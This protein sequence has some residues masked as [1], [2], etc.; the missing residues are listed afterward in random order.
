MK[1]I[2][3]GTGQVGT[4]IAKQLAS[5]NNEVTVIDYNAD[6]IRKITDTLDVNAVIGY[7][8]HPPTLEQAGGSYS[9]MIIAVTASDEVNMVICQVAYSLFSIP[10]KIARVRNQLYLDD[11]WKD[12]YRQNHLPI[13]VIISPELEVAKAINH[14]L[15]V[16][17]AV[18]TIPYD[19]NVKLI[20]VR[21]TKYSPVVNLFTFKIKQL[22]KQINIAIIGIFR[23]Q[24]FIFPDDKEPI[25]EGDE[26]FFF[27][28]ESNVTEAMALF[29]HEEEEARKIIIVG[30]GNIGLYL[31]QL[32]EEEA[33]NVNVKIIE[34]DSHRADQVAQLLNH[35]SI[36][37]GN[38][39]DEEI[40]EESGVSYAETV[41]AVSNDDEVNILSALLAKR[42]GTQR[43][44]ALINN[45]TYASLIASLGIDVV[46]NPREITVS[47]ILGQIRRGRIKSAHTICNGIIEI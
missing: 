13:D 25:I 14:R 3:C 43:S 16:P 30:G 10:I 27:A 5:E 37:N 35:S 36:I 23:D 6:K 33:H 39:L 26:I 15:H 4:S 7:A 44:I 40:L 21:C 17:G 29:G 12:L 45:N 18:D 28:N 2:V 24:K 31:A 42:F 9:D 34:I 20:A 1:I 41:I 46:V 11:R 47:S 19:N 8:S 22:A 38:A 32:I